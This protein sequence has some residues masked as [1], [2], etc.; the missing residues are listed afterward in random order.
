MTEDAPKAT[1]ARAASDLK[2]C[3]VGLKECGGK[4]CEI[5]ARV[6]ALVARREER[7]R[8]SMTWWVGVGEI[9]VLLYDG[10]RTPSDSGDTRCSPTF[11]ILCIYRST[12]SRSI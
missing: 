12:S 2:K 4:E 6:L 8:W 3:M 5:C 10:L 1:V 7:Y 11:V 9:V